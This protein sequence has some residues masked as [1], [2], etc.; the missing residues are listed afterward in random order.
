MSSKRPRVVVVE[1]VGE[2]A[3]GAAFR[4]L[5]N[6][7][8]GLRYRVSWKVLKA[9]EAGAAQTRERLFVVASLG[10]KKFDFD[11]LEPG[12]PGRIIDFLDP[13][14][15]EGWLEPH[16]YELLP[17][18]RV[19][20]SGMIFAGHMKG[21]KQREPAGDPGLAWT[22]EGWRQIHAAEGMGP[23]LTT[24]TN[25]MFLVLMGGRVRRITLDECRRLMGLPDG[26]VLGDRGVT[27]TMRLL[28]NGVYVPLV[29]RLAVEIVRQLLDGTT[30]AR[31]GRVRRP[32]ADVSGEDEQPNAA[33]VK[34]WVEMWRDASHATRLR[35]LDQPGVQAAIMRLDAMK[36]AGNE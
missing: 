32:Q 3:G 22:H 33:T 25:T 5:R 4:L 28:G 2:M 6:G 31:P 18:A 15:D 35:M 13:K 27:E 14:T 11:A 12:T 19:Q 24:K 21:P 10:K 23:T 30:P 16:E 26:F 7:L 34:T 9:S 29:R 17:T 8:R 20:P 1:N 36:E